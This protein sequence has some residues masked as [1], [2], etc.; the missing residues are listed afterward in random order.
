MAGGRADLQL[1]LR[2]LEP[3]DEAAFHAS[4]HHWD[5]PRRWHAREWQPEFSFAE[6]LERLRLNREGR[7]L[8][9]DRVASTL[10]YGFVGEDIVGTVSL[11]HTL[12][13]YLRWRGGHIGYAVAPPF[14]RRGYAGEMFRQSLDFARNVGLT[15]VM[16][17][18]DDHNE[19]SWR[20]LERAG[21]ELEEKFYDDEEQSTARRYWLDLT[22]KDRA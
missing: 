9:P 1:I 14:R 8:P 17:T 19:A 16:I 15:R 22:S 11:R 18:C 12:N 7:S 21:A 5:D 6:H 20:L 10:L 13:D 4:F 3:R 2:E